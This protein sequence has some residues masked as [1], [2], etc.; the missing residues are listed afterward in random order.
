MYAFVFIV[1]FGFLIICF[2]YDLM[3]DCT[4]ELSLM[5]IHL[6]VKRNFS[7]FFR[8]FPVH[9]FVRCSGKVVQ[10]V[11]RASHV[12]SWLQALSEAEG[13]YSAV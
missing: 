8:L 4:A 12:H 7:L 5:S 9:S 2:R 11:F 10:Q 13:T 6:F 3:F 1:K